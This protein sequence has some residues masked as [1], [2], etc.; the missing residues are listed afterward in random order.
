[1]EL[2]KAIKN[3]F[4]N[5]GKITIRDNYAVYRIRSKNELLVIIEHFNKYPLYTSKMIN[6]AYFCKI[7]DLINSK[8]HTNINGFLKL[9][10]L[11]NKLNKPISSSILNNLSILGILP[12]VEFESPILNKNPNLNPFWISG[13]ITGEGSFTYFTRSRKN[14]KGK[15]IKDYTLVMEVSQNSKD[16]FILTSIQNYFQV[17]KIY[18]ETRGITKFRIV[19][20]D[21]IINKL[22][23]HFINYPLEGRKVLQYSILINIVNI[24][25]IEPI[26]TLERDNK[27]Y[28]L[29]K[30]LSNL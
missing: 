2:L 20:K 9:V 4:N 10:S 3:F 30:K 17:G 24:L 6:F 25:V 11:I 29:I 18:N 21:E 26:K 16:W 14:S 15:I 1:L 7:L 27:V 8:V 23:P 28:D 5:L 13:F 12:N 22:I 19:V